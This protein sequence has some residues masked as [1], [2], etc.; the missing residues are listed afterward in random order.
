VGFQ[1]DTAGEKE[2]KMNPNVIG[3]AIIF[4][5]YAL[6][7]ATIWAFFAEEKGKKSLADY[8]LMA[9]LSLYMTISMLAGVA[10]A[11]LGEQG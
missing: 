11:L 1:R 5:L 10:R 2:G 8:L 6:A 9:F 4:I 3:A 7:L